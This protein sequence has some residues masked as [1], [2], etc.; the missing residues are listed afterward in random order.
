[1]RFIIII[2]GLSLWSCSSNNSLET[3]MPRQK[4]I[5]LIGQADSIQKL[6]AIPDIYTNKLIEMEIW[7]YGSDTSLSI[8]NSKLKSI[9]IK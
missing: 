1:M 8:A 9:N 5:E 3:E 2:F 4:I 7:Y 6:D